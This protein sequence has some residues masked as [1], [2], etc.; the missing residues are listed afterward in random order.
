MDRYLINGFDQ[1]TE[2][3]PFFSFVITLSGHGPYGEDNPSYQAHAEAAQAAAQRTDGNY[4][5]AV[6]GAMETDQFIGE[7]VDSLTQANLLEDTVLIF[8]ADH[9]N[10]YMMDDAL[11][12][13]IKGVDNMNMLQHTDFFIWSAD[14]EATQVDKVTSSVDVLPTIA[15]LF[16]LDTSGAFL[17]GHDGLGTRGDTSSSPT[18]VGTM[19]RPIGPAR[20]AAPATRTGLRRSPNSPPSATGCWR[21]TTTAARNSPHP[22]HKNSLRRLA[23][24]PHRARRHAI[25]RSTAGW[26]PTGRGGGNHRWKWKTKTMEPH[27]R[28]SALVTLVLLVAVGVVFSIFSLALSA[29]EGDQLGRQPGTLPLECPA[30]AAAVG[31]AVAGHRAGLAVLPGG[32]RCC[33]SSPGELFQAPLPQRAHAVGGPVPHPGGPG[34]VRPVPCGPHPLMIGWIV[35]IVACTVLLFFLGKGRP[36]VVPR[37]IALAAVVAVGA[38]SFFYVYLDDDRYNALA[39]DHAQKEV[40][41]YAATGVVYPFLHSVGD[42]LEAYASL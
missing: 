1:M 32:G 22:I 7:L 20:A 40:E 19:G 12:M 34:H 6:A 27:P 28:R 2:G 16:E 31:P 14:L 4:V 17:V 8:Y 26:A 25:A 3:N 38:V 23:L 13:D 35:V 29:W 15:N 10:Y 36:K 21:G 41:A 9:Y 33:S 39:G 37:L 42:Y 24:S 18:A 30:G 11:N 5:Y